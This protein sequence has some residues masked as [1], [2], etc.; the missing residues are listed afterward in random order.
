[1]FKG[2]TLALAALSAFSNASPV[3]KNPYDGVS[4]QWPPEKN[5]LKVDLGYGIYQGYHN[6]TSKLDIWQGVRYAAAPLDAL[7]FQAPAVPAVNRQPQNATAAPPICPQ[8][9][10]TIATPELAPL[11]FLDA[12]SSE[13][14]LF[15][16]V[17]APDNAE[18]LP[19]FVWIH[20]GGYDLGGAL[21]Y[22]P[23]ALI[24]TNDQ[25]FVAVIIQYRLGAFGFLSSEEVRRKGALN[26]GL[27]DQQMTLQWVQQYIGLFGGNPSRVTVA[28]ESAGAGS[29]MNLAIAYD[30]A[31]GNQLWTNGITASPFLPQ[32]FDYNSPELVD[33]YHEFAALVGCNENDSAIFECLQAAPSSALVS[34]NNETAASA[35]LGIFDWRP[36]VDGALIPRRPSEALQG[37][38]NGQRILTG[39]NANEGYVFTPQNITTQ[40]AFVQHLHT[41]F[42][43]LGDGDIARILAAYA[44]PNRP[45]DPAAPKYPTSGTHPPTAVN[46]SEVA[47]GHQQAANDFYAEVT[48]ACP[49]HWLA[50]AY[51]QK[52]GGDAYQYQFSV[53][54][55]FHGFDILF[56]FPNPSY[57][58]GA[59]VQEAMQK[60]FGGFVTGDAPLGWPRRTVEE[61][62]MENVNATGGT[63]VEALGF[64]LYLDPG[65]EADLAA[66]RADTWEGGRAER[67]E[68]LRELSEALV[69]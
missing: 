15:L 43:R 22:D 66:V 62:L 51:A 69:I 3:L 47:T 16:N 2:I 12:P 5:G 40:A 24:N 64:T 21:P 18:N 17:Y 23:S 57:P 61:P 36:V 7:R 6:S 50:S 68:L 63:P 26:A 28:G 20:G 48:F 32:Y 45:D 67:C 27:L 53:T 10:V 1:M 14:C 59:E 46:Q 19:V 52:E 56:Y 30:G 58:L 39:N 54:P 13:D 60:A 65:V 25:G 49:S 31:Q 8:A 4:H 44:T 33:Q 34:A 37:R 35:L 29:V 42:P 55:A 41:Y 9:T 11:F 38:T